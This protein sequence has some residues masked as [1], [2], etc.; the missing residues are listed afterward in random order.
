MKRARIINFI[1]RGKTHFNVALYAD[2]SDGYSMEDLINKYNTGITDG[3]INNKIVVHD[4]GTITIHTQK[5]VNKT[6]LIVDLAAWTKQF[7]A[8]SSAVITSTIAGPYAITSGTNDQAKISYDGGAPQT[9]TLTAGATQSAAAVAADINSGMGV[10]IASVSASGHLV[11]TSP[12]TGTSS[13]VHIVAPPS[14][15]SYATLGF[16]NQDI[17]GLAGTLTT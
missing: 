13:E 17:F 5:T 12:T 9:F 14:D 10:T 7:S 16:T 2:G 11:L 6:K 1:Q 3:E 15:S 8:P 4:N